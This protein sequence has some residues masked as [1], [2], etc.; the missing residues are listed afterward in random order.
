MG[1]PVAL[2]P[3]RCSGHT[4]GKPPYARLLA[5]GAAQPQFSVPLGEP[6]RRSPS[7]FEKPLNIQYIVYPID[8]WW[9][10]YR[11][12]RLGL[13]VFWWFSCRSTPP[14]ILWVTC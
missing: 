11:Q 2:G 12:I 9:R 5:R 7:A 10:K 8:P 6:S 13:V 3:T 4:W 14:W 1:C